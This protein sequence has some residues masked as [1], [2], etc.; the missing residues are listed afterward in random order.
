MA[1]DYYALFYQSLCFTLLLFQLKRIY[2]YKLVYN[3]A[4]IY[5]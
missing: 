2:R 1:A 3:T 4:D 5:Y